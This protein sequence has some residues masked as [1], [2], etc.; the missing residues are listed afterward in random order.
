MFFIDKEA[1]LVSCFVFI[2]E[3]EFV[4]IIVIALAS[5]CTFGL[6]EYNV[7]YGS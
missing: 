2:C 5:M 7:M 3:I 6:L 4:R 1:G